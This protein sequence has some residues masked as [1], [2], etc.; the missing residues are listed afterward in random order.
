MLIQGQ[1]IHMVRFESQHLHDPAYYR[2]LC[3]QNVVRYI[4]RAELINGISFPEIT[5]YV[6]QLWTN[7]Y[8]N[9]FA[10]F[11]SVDDK[12]IGTAKVNSLTE[13]GLRRDI[14]DVGIM[15]GE[16]EYR[17]KGLS[18]DIL[19]ATSVFAFDVLNARKLSAGAYAINIPVI[20]AFLR[21]GY[22]I[23][24]TLRQQ[25]QVEDRYCDHVLMSC[26]KDELIR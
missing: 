2:W 19:R 15:I 13:R 4:G 5:D 9:F 6:E 16:R 18:S 12:F 22:K 17:G 1:R 25:L 14:A 26:F 24:G 21:I 23:D 11:N 10:V 3:D 7:K 20:K 8:C